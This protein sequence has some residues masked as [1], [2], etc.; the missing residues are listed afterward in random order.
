MVLLQ[1]IRKKQLVAEGKLGKYGKILDSTPGKIKEEF[2][3]TKVKTEAAV[4]TLSAVS[5]ATPTTPTITRK[6]CC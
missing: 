4:E 6:V 5:T 3:D 2:S 1:A